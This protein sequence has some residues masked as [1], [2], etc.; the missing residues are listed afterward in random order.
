MSQILKSSSQS[1]LYLCPY[2]FS[3]LILKLG[4]VDV[5]TGLLKFTF[6]SNFAKICF[7]LDFNRFFS[8]SLSKQFN[9]DFILDVLALKSQ[10]VLT[11]SPIPDL[12]WAPVTRRWV[13][14]ALSL[15]LSGSAPGGGATLP[16][17][18][19]DNQWCGHPGPFTVSSA[20]SLERQ[21]VFV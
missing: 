6:C 2:W 15:P 14:S 19:G 16:G 18:V 10:R 4:G 5:K 3:G 17:S 20:L 7:R 9:R 21:S 1:E 12:T 13:S 11:L 8:T